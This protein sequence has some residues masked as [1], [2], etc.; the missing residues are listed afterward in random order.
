MTH[1]HMRVRHL[2]LQLMSHESYEDQIYEDS[3][4]DINTISGV[5]KRVIYG[6]GM[7]AEYDMHKTYH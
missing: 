4:V 5:R 7:A 6:M 3:D 1:M 2:Q